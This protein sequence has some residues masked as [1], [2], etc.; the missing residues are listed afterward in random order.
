MWYEYRCGYC[1]RLYETQEFR[2]IG[3][4]LELCGENERYFCRGALIRIV[5]L[6]QVTPA[7]AAPYFNHSVGQMV[8]STRDFEEK[9][10]IGS[11]KASEES[12]I[13][14]R[15]V[16]LYPA[17]GRKHVERVGGDYAIPE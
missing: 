8:T 16:P 3:E 9:L 4:Q 6:P 11:E 10:R 1:G 7:D 17:E 13:E 14:H 15:Y 2:R 12:G 5:S